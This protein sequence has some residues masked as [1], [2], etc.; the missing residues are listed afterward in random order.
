M[1]YTQV[2]CGHTTVLTRSEI[3]KD[4]RGI[5][6]TP[7]PIVII[8]QGANRVALTKFTIKLA[9]QLLTGEDMIPEE[10]EAIWEV[11]ENRK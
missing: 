5:H 9:L 6:I 1:D 8:E 2:N 3:D 7:C 10:L 11:S 4:A